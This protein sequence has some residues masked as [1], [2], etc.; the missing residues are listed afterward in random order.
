MN[1]GTAEAI[2]PRL[3]V[4]KFADGAITCLKLAGTIDEAFDGKRLAATVKGGTLVLDVGEVKKIS[5]F[6]IREWVDFVGS[7]GERVDAL[8]FVECSPKIVDQLNMVMN[9]AGKG[10]VFSFYAP[11]RCDYCDVDKRVLLQVDRDHDGIRAAKP[12]ER[13]C[14]TC[15]N[16]CYFDE[17]ATTFFSYLSQQ[18]PFELEPQVAAFLATR[19]NYAVEGSARRF[20]AEK[21]IEGRATYV[22]LAGDLDT[23]FPTVKVAEGLEG[24]VVVDLSGVGKIDPAG[25]AA[26]R[27]FIASVSTT[28]EQVWLV[29]CPPVFLERLARAED[30]A[31]AQV[32]SFSPYSSFTT[33]APV[34]NGAIRP[35]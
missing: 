12:P 11:Y 5:S 30:L 8:I 10:R 20:R 6:G 27:G 31:R 34:G 22:R 21:Q 23:T 9:F 3:H 4:D 24:V 16:P 2:E 26:W 13:P 33:I 1:T 28:C 7:A 35:V 25:A 14:E 19:L 32:V 18:P 29:G 15:G 17:D